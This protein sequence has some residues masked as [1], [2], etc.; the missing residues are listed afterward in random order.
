MC[1]YLY[2]HNKYTQYIL[3]YYANKNVYFG[4]DSLFERTNIYIYIYIYSAIIAHNIKSCSNIHYCSKVWGHYIVFLLKEMN[5]FI[6]QGC[7]K[8]I[9]S[10]SQMSKDY[11]CFCT[12]SAHSNISEGPRDPEDFSNILSI[13]YNRIIILNCTNISQY[14]SQYYCDLINTALVSI[15]NFFQNNKKS[16]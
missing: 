7:I 5:T 11:K 14:Y 15:R 4:C 9:I 3:I 8:L 12:K 6:Q 10:N 2:I 16:Y 1:L 13:Y